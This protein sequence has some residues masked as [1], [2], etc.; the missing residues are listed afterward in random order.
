MLFSDR[1]GIEDLLSESEGSEW[2]D[3][4]ETDF[5]DIEEM[6]QVMLRN[7]YTLLNLFDIS[8][9]F[10]LLLSGT[11]R[12]TRMEENIWTSWFILS[13]W[14]LLLSKELWHRCRF[15]TIRN[16]AEVYHSRHSGQYLHGKQPI[17]GTSESGQAKRLFKLERCDSKGNVAILCNQPGN[18]A[19]EK[20][21]GEMLLE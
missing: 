16:P 3:D 5:E 10:L 8:S 17:C 7:K 2:S 20:E 1:T 6:T 12:P 19:C 14:I 9:L 13:M 21:F 15:I 4:S 11:R 18:G